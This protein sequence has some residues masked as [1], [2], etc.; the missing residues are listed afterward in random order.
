MA[1]Q[2]FPT[3]TDHRFETFR[4]QCKSAAKVSNHHGDSVFP[5]QMH[6][7]TCE[8]KKSGI[9]IGWICREKTSTIMIFCDGKR[10][11]MVFMYRCCEYNNFKL[12]ASNGI[13]K[14]ISFTTNGLQMNDIGRIAMRSNAQ[15]AST[16]T[17][18]QF[19]QT[20]AKMTINCAQKQT[21]KQKI[22]PLIII[23]ICCKLKNIIERENTQT[24]K[25]KHTQ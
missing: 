1:D 11:R 3:W 24:S 9:Y 7:C 21:H 4:H 22:F 14:L 23:I 19:W 12:P 13:S 25:P 10:F 5:Q 2:A 8:N 17:H 15:T 20:K 16:V 18:L 6:A